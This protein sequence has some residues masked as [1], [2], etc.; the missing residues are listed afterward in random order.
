MPVTANTNLIASMS[1]AGVPPLNGFFSKLIII[2]ACIQA[3]HF[4]YAF[5]AILGSLLTLASFMKVQRYAFSGALNE[6][7][8]NAK[9]VPFAMKMAMIILAVICVIGGL[10][11]VPAFAPFIRSAAEVLLRGREYANLILGAMK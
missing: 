7:W 5:C 1:I 9:E 2:L 10:L 4:V 11:V 6:K 3:N 8:K